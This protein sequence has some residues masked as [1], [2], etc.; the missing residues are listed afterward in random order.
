[1]NTSAT[2]GPGECVWAHADDQVVKTPFGDGIEIR[3]L[4]RGES[5]RRAQLVDIA[6]GAVWPVPDVHSPGAEEVYVVAGVFHD[7]VRAY[8]AGT[9]LHCPAGSVHTPQSE[10]G[11]QLFVFYPEG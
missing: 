9:F 11:C 7:G 4:W 10:A 1:M 3:T 2:P 6:A 5:G 8:P